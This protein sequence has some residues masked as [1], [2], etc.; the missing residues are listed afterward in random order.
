MCMRVRV[1]LRGVNQAGHAQGECV[2]MCVRLCGY[3]ICVC[4][5][6]CVMCMRVRV[7][8]RGVNQAGHAQGECVYMC[9]RVCMCYV[10]MFLCLFLKSALSL[11]YHGSPWHAHTHKYTHTHAHTHAHTHTHTYTHICI[12]ARQ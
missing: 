9:V 10:S 2:Y 3:V 7:Q 5:R 6:V 1:Q 11:A 8:L 4:V 12:H